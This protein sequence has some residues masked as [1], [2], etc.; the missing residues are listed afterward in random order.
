MTS[1]F[2]ITASLSARSRQLWRR[3]GNFLKLFFNFMFMI[4]DSRQ[5]DWQLFWLSFEHWWHLYVESGPWL[6]SDTFP[7]IGVCLFC[8]ASVYFPS[9]M[10]P[11][12]CFVDSI[13]SSGHGFD[14]GCM[15]VS[16]YHPLY[17]AKHREK[18]DV[19]MPTADIIPAVLGISM[20]S[21]DVA[22]CCNRVQYSMLFH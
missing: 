15:L 7:G 19:T 6:F 18:S 3:T 1:V 21:P 22:F 8:L 10:Q 13:F 4:W 20:V 17:L 2:Q 16:N 5:Q 11:S 9:Y 12:V 14:S